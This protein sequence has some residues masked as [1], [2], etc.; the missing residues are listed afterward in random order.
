MDTPP[1]YL[2]GILLIMNYDPWVESVNIEA[3]HGS[4][5]SSCNISLIKTKESF[6]VKSLKVI[7]EKLKI[8]Q[9]VIRSFNLRV[10]RSKWWTNINN[11]FMCFTN[12]I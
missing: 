4:L 9:L 2:Q 7:E 10:Y 5:L 1:F 12:S 3:A 8:L 6:T 11:G